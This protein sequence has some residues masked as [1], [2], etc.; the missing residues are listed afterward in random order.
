MASYQWNKISG[1]SQYNIASP[2]A[3]QTSVNDLT[4]GVY[5]FELTGAD[6]SGAIAK[7]TVQIIVNAAAPPPNQSP[8]TNAGADISNYSADQ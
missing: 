4:Q 1:P 2:N 3:V 6:N 8:V 5:A 7:D